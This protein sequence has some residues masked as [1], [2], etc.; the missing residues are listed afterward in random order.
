[1]EIGD[2][3]H[4]HVSADQTPGYRSG[5]AVMQRIERIWEMR[6]VTGSGACGEIESCGV[7][8]RMADENP[9]TS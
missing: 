4:A 2:A 3:V 7:G 5:F 8:L 9:D 1:M 6:Y